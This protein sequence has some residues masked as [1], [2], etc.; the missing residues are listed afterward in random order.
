MPW[1]K[2]EYAGELAV[3]SALVA[4]LVPWRLSLQPSAP[5]GSFFFA[6]HWPLGEL[7]VRIPSTVEGDPAPVVEAL[8][9]VYPG[10][11]L[12]GPFY[13]AD[14]VSAATFYGSANFSR[15]GLAWL[16][17]TGFVLVAVGLAVAL[18][19][20]E[21]GM[22]SL[23]PVDHVR[24]MAVLLGLATVAFALASA[25][26]WVGPDFVGVPVP[27]GVVVVGALAVALARVERV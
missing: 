8:R 17:G 14:V 25:Y 13:V 18:Y 9:D 23:L 5:F 4:A 22:A 16:A 21:A 26:Y 7:Q 24:L 2:A 15:A 6:V 20:D 10:V 3:V 19:R 1:V 27:V 11:D 12:F